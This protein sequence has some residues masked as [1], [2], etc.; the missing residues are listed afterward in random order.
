LLQNVANGL[1]YA[2]QAICNQKTFPCNIILAILAR[3]DAGDK[4]TVDLENKIANLDKKLNAMASAAIIKAAPPKI[5]IKPAPQKTSV[6]RKR[7]NFF[8][9]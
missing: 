3:L 5:S 2:G 8:V 9:E 6:T 1:S 7:A 4:K